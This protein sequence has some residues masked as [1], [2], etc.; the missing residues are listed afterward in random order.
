[1]KKILCV[2]IGN[3][4]RSPVMAAVLGM[5]LKNAGHGEVT[6]ESAGI[7]QGAATS[8]PVGQFGV[9]AALRLGLD[10][11]GHIKRHVNNIVLDV[12]DL[13]VTA[14]D[15]IA[16]ELITRGVPVRRIY[17]AMVPNPWPCQFQED[18]DRVTMPAILDSMY[19]VVSRY[20]PPE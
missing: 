15:K 4:D 17:N 18:Y 2:C 6:V 1:M 10:I 19:R 14:D 7:G 13:F 11:S 8:T 12:N 3:N 16:E 5:F 9:T 20:F